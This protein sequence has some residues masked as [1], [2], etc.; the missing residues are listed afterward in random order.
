MIPNICVHE[1]LMFER[2]QE[3]Q[4]EAERQ[5][6]IRSVRVEREQ[7]RNLRCRLAA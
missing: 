7:Q 4:K 1:Q 2:V 5:R 3:W 6:L